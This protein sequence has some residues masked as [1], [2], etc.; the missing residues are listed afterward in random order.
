ML[1]LI[2]EL[3]PPKLRGYCSSWA[4]QVSTGVYVANLPASVR[5]EI[6]DRV[7]RWSTP[8]TRAIMLW[9]DSRT[10]QGLECRMRGDPSRAVTRREGLLVS[11][12]LPIDREVELEF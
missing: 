11:R 5:D 8:E 3:A 7:E 9:P 12:W 1:L 10:E 4:L 6:W 2:L